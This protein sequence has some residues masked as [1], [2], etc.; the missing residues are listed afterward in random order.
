MRLRTLAL[1]PL[2]AVTPLRAQSPHDE[3]LRVFQLSPTLL[4][5]LKQQHDPIVL[6]AVRSEADRDLQ[7]GPWSVMQK[8]IAP[9]SGDKHDY[10][11]A[12]RYWWPN[13]ATPNHLPYIYKDGQVNPE[14][15]AIQDHENLTKTDHSAHALALAYYLTGEGKYAEQ[16]SLLLHV[17]FINPDT[18][19]NPNLRYAGAVPGK[20][21]SPTSAI[22]DARSIPDAIDA[23]G[24]LAGSPAWKPADTA[25]MVTWFTAYFD[26][27]QNSPNG[28]AEANT[29][30]NHANYYDQ[31]VVSIALFLGKD[32]VARGIIET[33]KT[34]RIAAQIQSDG[35]QPFE[36]KRAHG[37]SYSFF[38]LTALVELAEMAENLQID[39]WHYTA[40]NGASLQAA[41]DYLIPFVS[42]SP[43]SVAA[44][45]EG[46]DPETV[47]LPFLLASIHLGDAKY[48]A[49]T[50][51]L[52]AP[53]N[54][55]ALV[56]AATYSKH[57]K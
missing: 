13:P 22:I 4:E 20:T 38:N 40:P 8:P 36:L 54:T 45:L 33:A 42:G 16:A 39:L 15:N 5:Q 6:K 25:A 1:L 49:I 30:N 41:T 19:M 24:L 9:A 44:N 35:K 37:L 55:D 11:S 2:L 3:P 56:L 14:T 51:R 12:S 10:M 21:D 43:A 57:S 52:G 53:G 7:L 28:R 32:D 46:I 50:A 17:W 26:W 47:R 31:Q 34:R 18:R 27:L 48:G 29:I 23:I